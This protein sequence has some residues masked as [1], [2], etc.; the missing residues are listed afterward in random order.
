MVDEPPQIVFGDGPATPKR[1]K[2]N[3]KTKQKKVWILAGGRTI[4]KGM[5]VVSTTPYSQSRGGSKTQ[6]L[7]C[8]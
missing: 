5:C 1:E 4:S 3:K 7:F 2:K 6:T 8:F